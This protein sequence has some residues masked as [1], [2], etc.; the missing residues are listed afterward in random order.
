MIPPD[1]IAVCLSCGNE[2]EVRTAGV[3]KKRKCPVCGKYRVKMKSELEKGDKKPADAPPVDPSAS[4]EPPGLVEPAEP[5]AVSPDSQEN[6]GES[7]EKPASGGLFYAVLLLLGAG[8]VWLF[9]NS[10]HRAAVR[11]QQ[12]LEEAEEERCN[13]RIPAFPGF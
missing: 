3:G 1:K 9:L 5:A 6:S 7:Q 12:W 11:R 4:A 10:R 2:W 13:R 8:A